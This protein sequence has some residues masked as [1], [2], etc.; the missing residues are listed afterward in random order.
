MRACPACGRALFPTLL[1]CEVIQADAALL[2][3]YHWLDVLARDGES[4]LPLLKSALVS[5]SWAVRRVCYET[6][7]ELLE[8]GADPGVGVVQLLKEAT[9][10][11]R[12][13]RLLLLAADRIGIKR[14]ADR[15]YL[16]ALLLEPWDAD[17]KDIVRR[18]LAAN[19]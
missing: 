16:E 7:I 6:L 10:D 15:R 12:D 2:P 8:R 9:S 13:V 11:P 18:V 19:R 5:R 17:L 1:Q 14:D 3:S 4:L